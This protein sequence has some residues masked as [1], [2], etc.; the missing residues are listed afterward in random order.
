[1]TAPFIY[2]RLRRSSYSEAELEEWAARIEPFLAD[3]LDAFVFFRHD[4]DG[5]SPLRA[6]R[7]RA[8]L[9]P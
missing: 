7:L 4:E 5:Q 9:A 2:L 3:G 1:M 6:E 8:L